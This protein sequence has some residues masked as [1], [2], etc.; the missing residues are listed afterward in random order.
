MSPRRD[1]F[2]ADE[3]DRVIDVGLQHERTSLA[4]DR[5]AL[6]LVVVGALVI[7]SGS[8]LGVLWSLP[9]Y[10]TVG[11]GGLLLW[12]GTRHRRRREAALRAGS[13]PVR[14][15]LVRLTGVVAV[16]ISLVALLLL[17]VGELASG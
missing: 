11:L 5:T 2:E 4:W 17:V 12:Q 15:G 16:G 14:A 13:S 1:P 8:D 10:L 9:G 6:A 3:P 7:R